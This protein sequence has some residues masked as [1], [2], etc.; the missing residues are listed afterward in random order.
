MY[1]FCLSVFHSTGLI[2]VT[3][4][5][6]LDRDTN[7][8]SYAI[9]V[10]AID[11]GFPIPETATTTV[12]VKI[13][14][15]NDKPPRFPQQTY[16]AYVSERSPIDSEVLRVTAKDTDLNAKIEYALIEP[17]TA[18]TKGGIPLLT[19]ST[20]DYR[21]AFRID[22]DDGT[23]FVNNT[24]NYNYAAV[25]TLTV[26]AT[27]TM[28]EL[29]PEQQSDQ[30]EVTLYVQSFKDT[31]PL[32]KNKGWSTVR[33][34][35]EVKV[36]EEAPVESVV[37]RI[38][39]DDPV[40]DVPITDFELVMPD[41][42][43]FF[44][45]NE[46]TGEVMLLRRLD[47]ET[48]NKTTIDFVVKAITSNRKRHSLAYVNVTVENVNDNA[49]VFE[50]ESY[51]VTVLESDRHPHVIATVK[52]TDLD[53]VRTEKDTLLGYNVIMYS[54]F[55]SHSNL[56]TID[57]RT[58]E[59]R[60]APGQVLDREKQSVL[61]LVVVAED[62]P[63]RPQ[64]AKKTKTEVMVDVLDV[65]DNAPIFGQRSY[66]A[67]IPENVLVDTFVIAITAHDPDEGL[68]GEVR[69]DILNEGEANGK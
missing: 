58:G 8:E 60:I 49:P 66:T 25:I 11:A 51:R 30:T 13:Q 61:K 16:T 44:G 15:I 31:N 18:V 46:R 43:G 59:I 52:A 50:R 38:E 26:K 68:G 40:S 3:R 32:F 27:D 67:V 19:T 10:N 63:G 29:H 5:A 69:Y 65:N 21:Q 48:Y 54:L 14:D 23:I 62:A 33:P 24:L 57:N 37:F 22:P 56:F 6:R 45:L 4:E 64:E 42:D 36:K 34:K 20:Y 9:V 39:A 12:H 53:A 17:I 1:V 35:I 7:P 28:A 2:T 55:G 47:Y 41:V